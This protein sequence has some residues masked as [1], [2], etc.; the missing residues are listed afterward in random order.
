MGHSR[1][2]IVASESSS[3]RTGGQGISVL[4]SHE[5]A[6]TARPKPQVERLVPQPLVRKVERIA[7]NTLRLVHAKRAHRGLVIIEAN[8]QFRGSF[9]PYEQKNTRYR[10]APRSR[11]RTKG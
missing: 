9:P 1:N 11:F 3:V 5:R 7:L 6:K 2:G 8:S 10:N 4:S